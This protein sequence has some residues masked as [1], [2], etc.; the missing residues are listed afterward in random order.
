[1]T[2]VDVATVDFEA[3]AR[4]VDDAV[5]S[6]LA[7]DEP[8]RNIALEL[9]KAV[10]AFHH[11]ALVAIV[12]AL[13]ADPRGKELLFELVDDPAVVAVLTLQGIVR[14]SLLARAEAALA[15]VRPFLASHGGD[16]ELVGVDDGVARVR[17]KGACHGCSLSAVTLRESVERALVDGVEEIRAIEVFDGDPEVAFIPVSSIARRPGRAEDGWVTGPPAG[18]VPEGGM[19]RFDVGE[20]S[21]VIT[22]VAN[23]LAVFRNECAHQGMSLDGGLVDDGVLVCPWHGFRYDASTGECL[24]APGVQLQQV[25]HRVDGGLVR[26]RVG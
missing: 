6:A 1:M 15:R 7:L 2:A 10:E 13:R 14:P 23:R 5:A 12:R 8:A 20:E 24:S 25:P 22:N 9:K 18:T 11:D 16:V 21:F 26:L 17:L 4:R 19:V 3:S